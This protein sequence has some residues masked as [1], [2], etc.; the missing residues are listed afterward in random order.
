M[1][2]GVEET[3]SHTQ[4][5]VLVLILL[6]SPLLTSASGAPVPDVT[7]HREPTSLGRLKQT[8]DKTQDAQNAVGEKSSQEQS[9]VTPYSVF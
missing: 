5:L 9:P 1:P 6:H 8:K 3:T 4:W 2:S 7:S